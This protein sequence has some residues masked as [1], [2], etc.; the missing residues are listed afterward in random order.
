[1]KARTGGGM[2]LC[3]ALLAGILLF[4]WSNSLLP[5]AISGSLSQW[6][7]DL[8][9]TVAGETAGQSDGMLRKLAHFTEFCALGAVL[10]WLFAKLKKKIWVNAAICGCLAACADELLQHFAP[11]RA[12]RLTDV[13]IDTAGVLVGIGLLCLG[14]AIRKKKHNN[15]FGG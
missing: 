10:G 5:A 7:R 13:A 2:T 3:I 15:T 1:M 9:G 4:I 8:L 14:Y 11:G 12:P 6:L